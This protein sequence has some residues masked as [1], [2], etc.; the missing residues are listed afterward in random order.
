MNTD[1][2]VQL[3]DNR[4][5][6]T[7]WLSELRLQQPAAAQE[8]LVSLAEEM[9]LDLLS[10]LCTQLA[11]HLPALVAPDQALHALAQFVA[12]SRSPLSFGTLV[13]QD[14]QAL[15]VLLRLFSASPMLTGWLIED[16]SSF[17]LVRVTE[18]HPATRERLRNEIVSEVENLSDAGDVMRA[19]RVFKRRETLRIAYGELIAGQDVTVVAQQLSYLADAIC[20][21]AWDAAWRETAKRRGQPMTNNGRI[22]RAVLLGLGRFGGLELAYIPSLSGLFLYETEGRTNGE[23][24]TDNSVFFER[25]AQRTQ[26][27]LAEETA[28][29]SAYQVEITDSPAAQANRTCLSWKDTLTHYNTRGRTWE[30]QALIKARPVAGDMELGHELLDAIEPWV[31][32]RYL[33]RSDLSGI[34]ALKRRLGRRQDQTKLALLDSDGGLVDLEFLV[35]Y[36]QLINGGDWR[37]LRVANTLTAITQLEQTGCITPEESRQLES[38]Y[39]WLRQVEHRLEVMQPAATSLPTSDDALAQLA[40]QCGYACS[41]YEDVAEAFRQDYVQRAEQT[42]EV[43]GRLLQETFAEDK[44]TDLEADLVLDPRPSAERIEQVLAPYPFRDRQDAYHHLAALAEER[45]LFLSSRR[46]RHFLSLIAKPLLVSIAETPSPDATLANLCRVSDSIGGKGVLWELF[47]AHPPSL[48]LYVRLCSSSPYLTSILTRYPGMIDELLDSLMLAKLPTLDELQSTLDDLCSKVDEIEPVL[49]S[50]KNTQHLHVGVRELLGKTD[51]RSAT[52]T[53][54]DVAQVCLQRIAFQQHRKL[55]HK[56]GTPRMAGS[57]QAC[58]LTVLAMGKFGGHEPNY[59]SDVDVLFLYEADG[60]TYHPPT[61]RN[62]ETT[63]NQHFFSELGQ[64]VVNALSEHGSYGKLYDSDARLRPLTPNG[65]VAVS[66]TQFRHHYLTRTQRFADLRI[67]CQARPIF[68]SERIRNEAAQILREILTTARVEGLD[69]DAIRQCRLEIQSAAGPRN[70]KR[71]P[72]GIV[73]IE[74]ITQVLQLRYAADDPSILQTNTL[75]A[76][77]AFQQREIIS[78]ED[79]EFLSESYRF[80]RRVE[81]RLRLLNTTARHDIPR[82]PDDLAKLAY[83][84]EFPS[85]TSLEAECAKRAR[86]NRQ[87]FDALLTS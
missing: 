30:R 6:A 61:I 49:H 25:V 38:I 13:E 14:E 34:K 22:A 47:H 16:P 75:A 12:T 68:G 62:R 87:L 4:E 27:L 19:L 45:V 8:T 7:H 85:S 29:G 10:T 36:L 2:L 81:A 57:E 67:F 64:R 21:A 43:M 60:F 69:A 42:Q 17:D 31:Y 9:P 71:G 66:L 74:F 23:R 50:F 54:A 28:L 55:V 79:A 20:A 52:G 24:P 82:E 5:L 78:G 80:L 83:L 3:L 33:S 56:Y 63:S 1:Q 65:P 11:A 53:L 40:Q 70:I 59:H 41:E 84:L 48:A 37:E 26:E 15:P 86:R 46:C 18:G 51:I 35:Q 72:G 44:D 32:R 39:V 58:E 76:I 73:D 77:E